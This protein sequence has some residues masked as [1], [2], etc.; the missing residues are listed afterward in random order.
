M[1]FGVAKNGRDGTQAPALHETAMSTEPAWSDAFESG[2]L[3]E[4]EGMDGM[5]EMSL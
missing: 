5:S 3:D 1:W 2:S 4:A